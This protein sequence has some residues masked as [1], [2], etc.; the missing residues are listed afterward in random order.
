[1]I[2]YIAFSLTTY[3]LNA[4]LLLKNDVES[5]K[6]SSLNTCA[7]EGIFHAQTNLPE[8]VSD[9]DASKNGQMTSWLFVT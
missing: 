4:V 1:M 5:A 9:K 8:V 6:Q 7:I 2:N 3:V